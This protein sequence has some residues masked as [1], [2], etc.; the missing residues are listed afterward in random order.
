MPRNLRGTH[1]ATAFTRFFPPDPAFMPQA[2]TPTRRGRSSAHRELLHSIPCFPGRVGSDRSRIILRAG[3]SETFLWF[4]AKDADYEVAGPPKRS[5][6]SRSL[7]PSSNSARAG[8]SRSARR[9]VGAA[10]RPR[11]SCRRP[12]C[13]PQLE[14]DRRAA[15]QRGDGTPDRPSAARRYVRRCPVARAAARDSSAFCLPRCAIVRQP[16]AGGVLVERV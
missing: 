10:R 12:T 15:R 1:R 8:R 9:A 4:C 2:S 13:R 5:S 14:R 6:D 3:L 11:R 7:T 16:F